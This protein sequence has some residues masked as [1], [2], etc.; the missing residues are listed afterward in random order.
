MQTLNIGAPCPICANSNNKLKFDLRD[1][2][3]KENLAGL[4][5]QCNSC[6]MWFKI[7][8]DH[9]Q[10]S[11]TYSGNNLDEEYSRVYSLSEST[12]HFFRSILA[13]ISIGSKERG[14][15]LLD[16]GAG[17]GGFVE[18]AANQGFDSEGVDLCLPHVEDGLSRGLKLRHGAAESISEKEE[19]NYV[20]MLDLIEHVTDPVSLLKISHGALK[21]DGILVVYTPN[22]RSAIVLLAR[23]LAFWGIRKPILEI[24]GSNHICFFDNRTMPMA[25]EKAGFVVEKMKLSP[26]DPRRPG[27]YISLVNLLVVTIVEWLG[28]PFGRVFRMLIYARK[29]S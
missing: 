12:R 23:F 14:N 11:N 4:V 8:S 9:A 19:F 3:K 7:I 27:Q 16:I 28:L 15:K 17:R 6:G 5:V 13:P 21:K 25:L 20:T 24:F 2:Y 29:I 18:E 1:A 26:Y 10:F 22:H